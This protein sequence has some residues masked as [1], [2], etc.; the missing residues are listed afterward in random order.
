MLCCTSISVLV[1]AKVFSFEGLATSFY[2]DYFE[3]YKYNFNVL[4]KIGAC[5]MFYLEILIEVEL[6]FNSILHL[7]LSLLLLYYK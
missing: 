6:Q 7:A 3:F 2:A 1:P 4:Y 5:V